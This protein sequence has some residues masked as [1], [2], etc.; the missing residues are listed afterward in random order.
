[1]ENKQLKTKPKFQ[2][3][4]LV[5]IFPIVIYSMPFVIRY[6]RHLLIDGLSLHVSTTDF[7]FFLL[8]LLLI[9]GECIVL[10]FRSIVAALIMAV[11]FLLVSILS[12][13][14]LVFLIS[15]LFDSFLGTDGIDVLYYS[16]F[17]LSWLFVSY[18]HF[19]WYRYA[20][21]SLAQMDTSKTISQEDEP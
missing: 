5:S 18:V 3:L 9:I 4:L 8:N 11:M 6:S 16:L 13:A 12:L 1:M 15:D 2:K 21:A 20:K 14:F 10:F 17:F 19:R 7:K